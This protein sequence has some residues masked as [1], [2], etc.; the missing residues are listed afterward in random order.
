MLLGQ[1]V[2]ISVA[3]N[4]FFVA[5]VLR[6]ASSEQNSKPVSPKRSREPV[7]QQILIP[8]GVYVPILL[9]HLTVLISPAVARPDSRLF[10]PNLLVMHLLIILPLLGSYTKLPPT[11]IK[12][13]IPARTF[14]LLLAALALVPRAQTYLAL[15]GPLA[16]LG[17]S[18]LIQGLWTTLHEHPAQSSI[19]YDIVWTTISFATYCAANKGFTNGMLG[20]VS[21]GLGL[22][23]DN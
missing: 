10:L 23:L 8:A 20:L 9:S 5:V 11:Q 15:S 3:S 7:G 6:R 22:Y 18:G 19:G 16:E 21:P 14:Y 4:L 13:G 2:A 17:V 12:S 1:F